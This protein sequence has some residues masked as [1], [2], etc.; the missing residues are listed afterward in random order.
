MPIT[1]TV[2][3]LPRSGPSTAGD[4]LAGVEAGS[5][6]PADLIVV[7]VEAGSVVGSDQSLHAALGV[8]AS[9]VLAAYQLTGKAGQSAQVL[10]HVGESA[11]RVAFLGTGDRSARALR[12]AGGELGR[13]L[14]P[15]DLAVAAVVAGKPDDQVRAFAEGI[16]LGSYRYSEK[17]SASIKEAKAAQVHLLAAAAEPQA[18]TAGVGTGRAG[19]GT[20]GVGTGGVGTGGSTS[21]AAATDG[22]A[23]GIDAIGVAAAFAAATAM[24]RDLANTPSVRKSP[25][26]LA[27]AAVAV[28]AQAGLSVRVRTETEL[29]AEG[30]GGIVAVGAGSARQPRLIEL[31]YHPSAAAS[32]GASRDGASK[33][34]VLIGKGITFDSGGLSLKPNDGMKTM[35]TDMAGGG[36]VIAAMSVMAELGV[37]HRVTG[38]IAA[39]EN[40]PSGSAYRPG[41]VITHFGGR[42]VEVLNTDAE[43]RLV[44]ADALAYA[45][46]MLAPDV[47]VDIATLT[48]AARIALGTTYAALYSTSDEL[49]TALVE[50]GEASGERLWRMPLEQQYRD[51]LDSPVADLAHIARSDGEPGSIS[52]ALFL[53]EFVGTR[54]WAHL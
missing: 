33:H 54:P 18:G 16:L 5:C 53:R 8:G 50:A 51:A 42:T 40:M 35:K 3:A 20:A 49:A 19:T 12:R 37:P 38:L 6:E 29:A 17:T 14:R 31:S 26:W 47:L 13:M 48:G 39:A 43:G 23:A 28:G 44:L 36:A 25:Q 32:A 27:D 15:G 45:D 46:A 52:A 11:V 34:V 1:T 24:A 10:A 9:D 30:F 2:T 22:L 41:D 7:P 21:E 4:Y